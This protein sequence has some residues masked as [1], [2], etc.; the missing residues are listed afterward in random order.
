ML[1]QKRETACST[2]GIGHEKGVEENI[3]LGE[4]TKLFITERVEV[5]VSAGGKRIVCHII[6]VYL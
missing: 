1:F 6:I 5:P 3:K 2:E 4:R